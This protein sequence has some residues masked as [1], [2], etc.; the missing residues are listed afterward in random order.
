MIFIGVNPLLGPLEGVGPENRCHFRA[1]K[2]LDFQGP[3]LPMALVMDI[4]VPAPY[5][6]TGTF[7]SQTHTRVITSCEL[8]LAGVV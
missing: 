1:Q 3:H 5:K 7:N 8:L 6:K 2:S 4:P